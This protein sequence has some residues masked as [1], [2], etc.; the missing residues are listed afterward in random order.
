M[1]TWIVLTLGA[2]REQ[3]FDAITCLS[4]REMGLMLICLKK[5]KR[6]LDSV[7]ERMEKN[8]T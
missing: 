3:M 5:A 2:M 4:K 7:I 1:K 6:N 8:D